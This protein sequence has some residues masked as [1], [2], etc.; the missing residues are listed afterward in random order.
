MAPDDLDKLAKLLR[1]KH[2]VVTADGRDETM[3]L[4]G[5]LVATSSGLQQ[6]WRWSAVSGLRRGVLGEAVE[7]DETEHPAAALYYILQSKTF[8]PILILLDVLEFLP[9]PKVAR[10]LKEVCEAYEAKGGTVFFVGDTAK[11]PAS[12]GAVAVPFEMSLPNDEA[13]HELVQKEAR[14]A[15]RKK[16]IRVKVSGRAM[17]AMVRN[18]RGL[19]LAQARRVVGE[20]MMEDFAFTDEDA[21]TMLATKRRLLHEDGLLEYIQTPLGLNEIA[22]L[23]N[24]KQWLK[25]RADAFSDD[26]EDFGLR[27]PRG[28]LL[29]G[30]PGAGKSLCAKAVASSWQRPLLRLDPSALYDRFIGESERR[31]RLALEQAE[32]MSP[33]VLWIDEIEK[34]FASAAAQSNDGGLSQRMFGTLL[35]WMQEHTTPVFIVATANNIDA[36]PPELLRKGRFDEIFFVDLPSSS[37]RQAIFRIHLKR[38]RL[39]PRKFDLKKLAEASAGYT[40]AEIEAAIESALFDGFPARKRP[41]TAALIASV[42][43]SPPLSVTMGEKLDHLR[44]WAESRTVMA[45]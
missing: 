1:A 41:G 23:K 12:I 22:G 13:L 34:G 15:N 36:L 42:R 9:D 30:V 44:R 16:G 8:R 39:D 40:G 4:D 2:P 19:T 25:V 32:A 31:L 28:M 21:N 5:L 27:P 3:L 11:L 7:K 18:L 10:L 45:N 35:N 20:A 38:R 29:L 43:R 6:V 37:V 24:L 33:L 17:Q 14:E 26:A